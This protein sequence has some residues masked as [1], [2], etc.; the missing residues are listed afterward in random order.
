MPI[1]PNEEHR[2]N[3]EIQNINIWK[4]LQNLEKEVKMLKKE[5]KLKEQTNENGR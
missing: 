1:I 4:K 3:I 2:S 5:L